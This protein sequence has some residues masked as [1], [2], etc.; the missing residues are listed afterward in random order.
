MCMNSRAARSVI[1]HSYPGITA[2]IASVLA[3]LARQ[4]ESS[5]TIEYRGTR[6]DAASPLGMIALGVREGDAVTIA[7]D[8]VDAE[9]AVEAICELV[10]F[11]R[12]SR[13]REEM[14]GLLQNRAT[15]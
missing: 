15:A 5:I 12:E 7:A 8:G 10:P 1:F 9:D 6:A 2:A 3:W 13:R 14:V 11:L 4:F